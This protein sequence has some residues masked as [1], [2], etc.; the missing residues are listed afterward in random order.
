MKLRQHSQDVTILDVQI[1]HG[2]TVV[3]ILKGLST[4]AFLDLKRAG[5]GL[6]LICKSS[7]RL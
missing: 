1:V 5:M 7:I 6:L 3:M 2:G 4:T